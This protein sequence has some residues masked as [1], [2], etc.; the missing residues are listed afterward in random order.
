VREIKIQIMKAKYESKD[1][2]LLLKLKINMKEDIN[3]DLNKTE[4][5]II[6]IILHKEEITQKAL[7]DIF[8]R[9]KAYRTVRKLENKGLVKRKRYGKTYIIK[10]L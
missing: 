5:K 10:L 9:V 8:G 1:L 4:K 3:V 6:E 2:I 7:G